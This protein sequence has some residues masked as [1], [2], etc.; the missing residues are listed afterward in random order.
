MEYN[1]KTNIGKTS[2]WRVVYDHKHSLHEINYGNEEV[3]LRRT[4]L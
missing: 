2:T 1:S 3:Q 4:V